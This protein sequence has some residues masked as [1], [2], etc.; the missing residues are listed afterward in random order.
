MGI[1]AYNTDIGTFEIRKVAD[2]RYELWIEDEQIDIYENPE[3]AAAD[4]ADFN[5]GYIEWDRFENEERNVP[6]DL[7]EWSRVTEE[8]PG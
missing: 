7:G 6:S 3:A 5:T 4:V 8:T 2:R 1:Y